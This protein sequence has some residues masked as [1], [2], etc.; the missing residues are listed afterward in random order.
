MAEEVAEQQSSAELIGHFLSR[1]HP[2]LSD[3]VDQRKAPCSLAAWRGPGPVIYYHTEAGEDLNMN[4]LHNLYEVS[5]E[6]Y[7]SYY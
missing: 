7:V 2:W 6:R 5:R 1:L 4:I 3:D